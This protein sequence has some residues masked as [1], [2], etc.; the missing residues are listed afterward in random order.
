MSWK[1]PPALL[2][3]AGRSTPG[4]NK[5]VK[6]SFGPDRPDLLIE[7]VASLAHIQSKIEMPQELS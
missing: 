6:L 4:L 2:W 5:H 1:I 3:I 7:E